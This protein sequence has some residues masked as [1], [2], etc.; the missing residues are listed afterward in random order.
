MPE[1]P[2]FVEPRLVCS[3]CAHELEPEE[4]REALEEFE[5][6][7]CLACGSFEVCEVEADLL[8]E[9]VRAAQITG[10]QAR[11]VMER[12]P[13]MRDRVERMLAEARSRVEALE[14]TVRV[15]E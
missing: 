6:P 4:I 12:R 1:Q 9:L 13:D 8:D 14:A 3:D 11:L 15:S 5:V 10:M 2:P 7:R